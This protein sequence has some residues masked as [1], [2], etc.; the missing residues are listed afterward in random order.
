MPTFEVGVAG[1]KPEAVCRWLFEVADLHHD[2]E[3]DDLFPGSGAV[4]RAWAAFRAAPQ[5]VWADEPEQ[6]ELEPGETPRRRPF[7]PGCHLRGGH[8]RRPT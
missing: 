2:D 1:A 5:I 7:S 8:V 3:L 6:P 4:S